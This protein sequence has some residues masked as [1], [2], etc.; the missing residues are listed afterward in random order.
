MQDDEKKKK[1]KKKLHG[2]R[3]TTPVERNL[4]KRPGKKKVDLHKYQSHRI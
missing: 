2:N 3:E 1:K 4:N